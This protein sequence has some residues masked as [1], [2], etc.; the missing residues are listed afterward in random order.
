MEESIRFFTEMIS[1]QLRQCDVV[2]NKRRRVARQSQRRAANVE[3]RDGVSFSRM[4]YGYADG[5]NMPIRDPYFRSVVS[6]ADRAKVDNFSSVSALLP[7]ALH[8]P[9]VQI[10]K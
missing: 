3:T 4:G 10:G 5:T 8:D 9:H 7:G 1:L 6:E 2:A